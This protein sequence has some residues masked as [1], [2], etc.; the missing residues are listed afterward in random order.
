MASS[1]KIGEVR[2]E[3]IEPTMVRV[4]E[5]WFEMG[6]GHGRDDEKPV[7]RVWVDGFEIGA[8][9]ATNAEYARFVALAGAAAPISSNST[10][11]SSVAPP[12]IEG[13]P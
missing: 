12:G 3:A 8:Y 9:Q 2:T 11:K 13:R 6:C 1:S 4:P 7:H 5:G 10:S